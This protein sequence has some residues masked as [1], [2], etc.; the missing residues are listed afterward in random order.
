[1]G[2]RTSF[3]AALS[4]VC[5]L[6]YRTNTDE[7]CLAPKLTLSAIRQA[8]YPY[9]R[10]AYPETTKQWTQI[11]I[12]NP[13]IQGNPPVLRQAFTF[14]LLRSASCLGLLEFGAEVSSMPEKLLPCG[15][16]RLAASRSKLGLAA[17]V[18]ARDDRFVLSLP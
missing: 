3:S 12:S 18:A 15:P 4:T 8:L 5:L 9:L 7:E 13:A 6:H 2:V 14:V 16:T 10:P 11:D 17:V 1:M